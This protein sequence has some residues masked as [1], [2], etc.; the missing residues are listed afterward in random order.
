MRPDASV[1]VFALKFITYFQQVDFRQ[2]GTHVAGH[3]NTFVTPTLCRGNARCADDRDPVFVWGRRIW[4]VVVVLAITAYLIVA[5][6]APK[7]AC[8]LVLPAAIVAIYHGALAMKLH[9]MYGVVDTSRFEPKI[10]TPDF[11]TP[12]P[13]RITIP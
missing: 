4:Q 12:L 8:L 6:H 1:A 2:L 3:L 10:A 5:S 7:S 13:P 9:T 11:Y